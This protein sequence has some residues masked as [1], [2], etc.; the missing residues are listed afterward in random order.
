MGSACNIHCVLQ[1]DTDTTDSIVTIQYDNTPIEES[2]NTNL[3]YSIFAT[4]ENGA[5]ILGHP[6][7]LPMRHFQCN[8]MSVFCLV[9]PCHSINHH[10]RTWY[11]FLTF[12][13]LVFFVFV[14][15]DYHTYY[16]VFSVSIVVILSSC[17]T[18]V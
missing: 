17:T 12:F 5:E 13:F 2:P 6:P 7:R 16:E 11:S 8:V 14:F 4:D 1:C 18:I 15:F 9:L 10:I 3:P